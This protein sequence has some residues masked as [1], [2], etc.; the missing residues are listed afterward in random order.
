MEEKALYGVIPYFAGEWTIRFQKE[1]R[2]HSCSTHSLS[3]YGDFPFDKFP[4]IP[5]IDFRDNDK[6]MESLK[7]NWII[8]EVQLITDYDL[9]FNS[10]K[11]ISIEQYLNWINDLGIKVHN[12]NNN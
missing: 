6:V 2:E 1:E 3:G 4:D 12:W 11:I 7:A 9:K 10:D 8:E 5:V